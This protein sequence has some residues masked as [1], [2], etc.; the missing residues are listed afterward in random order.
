MKYH[1]PL[2]I[3]GGLLSLASA[4][5]AGAVDLDAGDYDPA[6]PGTTLALVYL[7]HAERDELDSGG[8]TVPGDNRLNTDVGI[9]RLVHYVSIAGLTVAPQI[10]VPVVKQ[11]GLGDQAA[12]GRHSGVGDII[13]AAPVWL[14][15][16]PRPTAISE[17]RPISIF[18][19]AITARLA[20]SM[21]VKTAGNSIFRPPAQCG[22]RPSSHGMRAP[23][24]PSTARPG[25]IMR[26]AE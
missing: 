14:V 23:T 6:K 3:L 26:V 15:N 9:F 18:R 25:A 10:L 13:L 24:S 4:T 11:R 22:S 2:A 8:K 16:R 12:L 1:L 21:R 20:P 17:S 7:Q 19:R 5:T